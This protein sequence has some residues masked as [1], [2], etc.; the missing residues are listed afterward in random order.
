[1]AIGDTHVD[2]DDICHGGEGREAGTNL[3]V[4]ACVLDLLRLFWTQKY[5]HIGL[6]LR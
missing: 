2:G 1:M 3:C 6:M 4:E 5:Q